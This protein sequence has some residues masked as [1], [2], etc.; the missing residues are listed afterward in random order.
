MAYD[1]CI[2]R[3]EEI[4]NGYTAEFYEPVPSSGSKDLR[5]GGLPDV[6]TKAV[7]DGM[8]GSTGMPSVPRYE[9]KEYQYPTLGALIAAIKQKLPTL[10]RNASQEYD[11]SFAEFAKGDD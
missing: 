8:R 5:L 1:D 11:D 2:C 4:E 6:I 9:W 10:S 3:I 7:Q